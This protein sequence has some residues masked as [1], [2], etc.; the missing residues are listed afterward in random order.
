MPKPILGTKGVEF[1]GFHLNDYFFAIAM[2]VCEREGF[3][4]SLAHRAL[5]F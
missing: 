4:S 3:G 5:P 1:I 2:S